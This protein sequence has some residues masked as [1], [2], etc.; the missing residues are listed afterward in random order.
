MRDYL[1]LYSNK[2]N[3]LVCSG[4][5]FEDIHNTLNLSHLILLSHDFDDAQRDD[6]SYLDYC[7]SHE[8]NSLSSNEIYNFGDLIFSDFDTI[9][10]LGELSE[11]GI[12]ELLYFK[13][14]HKP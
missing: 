6:K 14:K 12:S 5:E 11:L 9:E 3:C 2:S 10:K 4:L 7:D 13:H 1:Y 8:L